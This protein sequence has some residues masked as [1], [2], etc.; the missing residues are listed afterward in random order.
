MKRLTILFLVAFFA[1][2][3]NAIEPQRGYRGFLEW[4][5]NISSVNY[6]VV[7]RQTEYFTGL[8][9]SHGYQFNSNLFAGVGLTLDRNVDFDEWMFPVFAQVRTD[10]NWGG[11]TPFGD[12]RIGY[13]LTDGGGIYFSPTVG[14]RFN[15]GRKMNLNVGV[16]LTLRGYSVEKY[17]DDFYE[18]PDGTSYA[19]TTYI[20]NSHKARAMF[21]I[22]VGIDF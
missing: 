4:D 14:Y 2:Y 1:V 5:N 19:T 20:G 3:A 15:W 13:N 6:D 8:S 11:F 9:T 18:T 17:Y 12:L 7:G 10:Q 21:N 22:R 16:G